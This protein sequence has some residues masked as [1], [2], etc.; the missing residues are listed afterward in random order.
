MI[1]WL[2]GY[3]V[4]G[5]APLEIGRWW[6]AFEFV[7]SLV[8]SFL[9]ANEKGFYFKPSA[10]CILLMDLL[11]LPVVCSSNS[12]TKVCCLV[13]MDSE[14]VVSAILK[15]FSLGSETVKSCFFL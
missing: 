3:L 7:R 1:P 5:D 11:L 12:F 6:R 2:F 10:D 13:S 8:T 15:H 14:H 9:C 4:A